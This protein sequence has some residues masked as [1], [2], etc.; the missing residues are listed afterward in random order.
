MKFKSIGMDKVREHVDDYIKYY[1]KER[2]QEK[3]GYHSPIE[4]GE[5]AA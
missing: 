2:I 4:F 5:M 1:N 3:L